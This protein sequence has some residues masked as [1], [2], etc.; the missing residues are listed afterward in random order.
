[1][2]FPIIRGRQYDL[3]AIR[4][5][6]TKSLLSEKII[7]VVEPVKLSPTLLSTVEVFE[8]A[9]RKLVIISNPIVGS[10]AGELKYDNIYQKYIEM[11]KNNSVVIGHYFNKDSYFEISKIKETFEKEIEN[12]VFI[13]SERNLLDSYNRIFED[14]VPFANLIPQDTS[15]RRKLRGKNLVGLSDKFNKQ[16]RNADYLDYEHEFFSEEHLYFQ[17]EGYMGFSDYSI[18]GKEYSDSGF[19]PYAV[20]IHIVFPNQEGALE[21]MHFVSNSNEDTSDPAGKFGEALE[22]MMNWYEKFSPNELIETY[23]LSIFKEHYKKGTY[24]GLPT[25]KKLSIMHHLELIGRL[26]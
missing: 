20:A 18:V 5:L 26:F 8:K 15:F 23:A 12:I 7:P 24:P 9:R 21:I 1:M 4:E 17:E 22:K 6:Q 3:L 10:L 25:I 2:Y 14:R 13:H 19:A 16:Q 11:M